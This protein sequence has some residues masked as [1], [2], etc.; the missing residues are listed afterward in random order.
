MLAQVERIHPNLEGLACSVRTN[1]NFPREALLVTGLFGARLRCLEKTLG[2]ILE[3]F[4]I[5]K[6]ICCAIQ[7]H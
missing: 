7:T 4:P 5:E 6:N 3:P 1:F 2:L